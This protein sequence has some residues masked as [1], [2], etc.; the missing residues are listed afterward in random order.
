M[1]KISSEKMVKLMNYKPF[2]LTSKSAKEFPS[3]IDKSSCL[4]K[5]D[6]GRAEKPLAKR[7]D[8]EGGVFVGAQVN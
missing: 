7:G 8:G 1:R 4:S 2:L 5:N 3:A 6:E